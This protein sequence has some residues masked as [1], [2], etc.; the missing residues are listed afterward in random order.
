[1]QQSA[2]SRLSVDS[3]FLYQ[4]VFLDFTSFVKLISDHMNP[5]GCFFL[6]CASAS[7]LKIFSGAMMR[8]G[9]DLDNS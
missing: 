9:L 1:M 2:I 7:K 8:Y 5:L 3:Y 4:I 6:S